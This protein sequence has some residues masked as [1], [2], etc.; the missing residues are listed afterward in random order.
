MAL[1]SGY[2]ELLSLK[3]TTLKQLK[4][5]IE[6]IGLVETQIS[7]GFY[8]NQPKRIQT[9]GADVY[10]ICRKDL[11][12]HLAYIIIETLFD[13]ITDLLLA[14]TIA[15]DIKLTRAFKVPA[16]FLLHP[17]SMK[18]KEKERQALLV[19]T[20]AVNGKYYDLG[21]MIQLLLKER[22]IHA[23]A[24][25]TDGS[26]E[27]AELL[28]N[29]PTIA[30]MQYDAALSSRF[31]QP[32]FVYGENFSDDGSIPEVNKI[33]RIAVLHEE[34][35]HVI[36][37]REKLAYIEEK[38][39]W[40]PDSIS[41]L[42]ELSTALKQLSANEERLNVCLGARNSATQ[43]V[44]RAVLDLHNINLTSLISSFLSV[45]DMVRRL[46]SGEIDTGFFMSHVPGEATKTILDDPAIKLLSLGSKE[47]TPMAGA[48]FATATIKPC[49]YESQKKNEAGIQTIST[50]AVLVTTE[51][52]PF[53]VGTIT[54]AIFEG[55]AFLGIIGGKASMSQD[56]SSL[57]LHPSARGYYQKAGFLPSR[58]PIDWL[59]IIWR[60]LTI[61]VIL[62]GGYKGLL[63]L[64]RDRTSNWM[65]RR[66][67]AISIKASAQD[68]VKKLLD[69]R[70]E[71]QGRVRRRW[72]RSGELD[73][74]RW[75]YLF[76]LIDDRIQESQENLTLVLVSE[77]QS[78]SRKDGFKK[79]GD[80]ENLAKFEKRIWGL[81]E[82]GEL[83]TSQ[84]NMLLDIIEK[85]QRANNPPE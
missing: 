38:L 56:L 71:I 59:G 5:S 8:Q 41:T 66:V 72:W 11:P 83:N 81:F 70:D 13:N 50:R 75:R 51:D 7:M 28:I 65:G 78:I 14:H 17:G 35:L 84:C 79:R 54:Q 85:Q 39:G 80:H 22:G 42:S 18:F 16:G 20:G 82:K 27:N 64:R 67:F 77:I 9:V 1:E 63:K 76:D 47:L 24:I 30:I 34:K 37:R 55:E 46:H 4:Q 36:M 33:R 12:E 3:N 40:Q 21:V 57:P 60:S 25:H 74:P 52:L 53:D 2:C 43:V 68:S 31:G 61:F 6:G 15:Q 49:T 23:R 29:R 62:I 26:L 44:A 48:V 73:K 45:S 69:I 10:L 19:A 32:K 58:P